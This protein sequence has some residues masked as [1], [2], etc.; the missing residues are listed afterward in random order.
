MKEKEY[1]YQGY[2]IEQWI[3]GE[4]RYFYPSFS[5]NVEFTSIRDICKWLKTVK[6]LDKISNITSYCHL[7]I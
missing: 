6:W 2:I 3:F 5:G 7:F 4:K 1:I